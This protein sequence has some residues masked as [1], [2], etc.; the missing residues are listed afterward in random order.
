M[1][2]TENITKAQ[3]TI[4]QSI[5]SIEPPD[6]AKAAEGVLEKF[7]D[8]FLAPASS[9]PNLHGCFPGGLSYHTCNVLVSAT[10]IAGALKYKNIS[11]IIICSVF[12]DLGKIRSYDLDSYSEKGYKKRKQ[13]VP[14]SIQ[15][16]KILEESGF[17]LT[18]EEL[19]AILYHNGL[20]TPMGEE[21]KYD[22]LPLTMIVHWADLWSAFHLEN[23]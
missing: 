12:H 20:Y 14:H 19:Q 23:D 2:S 4:L 6:R 10:R 1:V 22:V 15:S 13:I 7:S 18:Q 5:R 16:I 11:S 3:E 9:R 17:K 8:F 21:I